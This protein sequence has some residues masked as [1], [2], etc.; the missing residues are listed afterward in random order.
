MVL[1]II[2][3]MCPRAQWFWHKTTAPATFSS[4]LV[5]F[6]EGGKNPDFLAKY[7]FLG[8]VPSL[9]QKN[10]DIRWARKVGFSHFLFAFFGWA[11]DLVPPASFLFIRESLLCQQRCFGCHPFA[12]RRWDT[13]MHSRF[14]V[15]QETPT[16]ALLLPQK[17]IFVSI[18]PRPQ[19]RC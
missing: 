5:G 2:G 1:A 12:V 11:L 7:L 16:M 18:W 3:L 19:Q 15:G 14:L 4:H 17:M 9:T 10:D 8:K 6:Y 13:A